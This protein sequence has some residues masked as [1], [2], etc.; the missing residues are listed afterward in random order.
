MKLRI[1]ELLKRAQGLV[2]VHKSQDSHW[3]GPTSEFTLS[4][5][6]ED[7]LA[8]MGVCVC[9]CVCICVCVFWG[10]EWKICYWDPLVFM[11][12]SC[13]ANL[14]NLLLQMRKW[15]SERAS[16]LPVVPQLV[17]GFE[18]SL[19]WSGISWVAQMTKNP[20]ANAGDAGWITGLGR[21]SG[22]RMATHCSTLAWKTPWTEEPG[23]LQSMG[24]QK[25][26]HNWVTDTFPFDLI[27]R[28][29]SLFHSCLLWANLFSAAGLAEYCQKMYVSLSP[30]SSLTLQQL[31][32]LSSA[33]LLL[34]S[35]STPPKY[36][37]CGRVCPVSS[38][39]GDFRQHICSEKDPA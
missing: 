38:E 39:L 15:G 6:S 34:R 30:N 24:S 26:R 29:L 5:T 13:E 16:D 27:W 7:S 11:N 9:V 33:Q 1:R 22:E 8:G 20:P 23:R 19:T 32:N 35:Y 3:S 14:P 25:V 21:S 10:G 18:S 17:S 28:P 4:I 31:R 37:W 36:G 2:G 12:S